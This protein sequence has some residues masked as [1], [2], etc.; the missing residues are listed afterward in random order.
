MK[1][2]CESKESDYYKSLCGGVINRP[3][4][5]IFGEKDFLEHHHKEG[6]CKRCL[7]ILNKLNREV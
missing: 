3:D 2:H 1:Y 5:W 7:K 6:R 4:T